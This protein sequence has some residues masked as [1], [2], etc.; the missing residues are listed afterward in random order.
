ME[1]VRS[2]NARQTE[3]RDKERESER[4]SER[5]R[6]REREKERERTEHVNTE[7]KKTE[8]REGIYKSCLP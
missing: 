5:E 4:Q 7:K 8:R 3:R 6:E 1:R 2:S